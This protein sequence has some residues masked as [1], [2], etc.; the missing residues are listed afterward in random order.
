[1]NLRLAFLFTALAATGCAVPVQPVSIPEISKS[2]S[3]KVADLRPGDEKNEE[4]FSVMIL[5]DAYG[6]RRIKDSAVQPEPL[7]LLQHRAFERFGATSDLREIKVHHFVTYINW[8]GYGKGVAGGAV[9]GMLGA[10]LSGSSGAPPSGTVSSLANA[11][12]FNDVGKDEWK[13][14]VVQSTEAAPSPVFFVVYID[15]EIQG[16]RVFTKTIYPTTGENMNIGVPKAMEAAISF[17]LD[18]HR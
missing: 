16:K 14:A 5:S 9:A 12:A 6:K 2:A 1:M 15:A 8:E 3:I 11:A 17:N 4:T 18:Q 7:R 13:R 10:A